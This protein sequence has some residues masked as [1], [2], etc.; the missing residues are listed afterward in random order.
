MVCGMFRPHTHTQ[1]KA[2]A[3]CNSLEPSEP[4]VH[5][6]APKG[7]EDSIGQFV[8]TDYMQPGGGYQNADIG[9]G[10]FDLLSISNPFDTW[11]FYGPTPATESGP[12]S[13]EAPWLP[14]PLH[15]GFGASSVSDPY[16]HPHDLTDKL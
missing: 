2:Q 13:L 12:T 8:G 7:S 11:A 16:Y 15:F 10:Y 6:E 5:A 1:R 4:P 9:I 14:D 3:S